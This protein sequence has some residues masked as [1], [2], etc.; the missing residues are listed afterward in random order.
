MFVEEGTKSWQYR[1]F[2]IVIEFD[3]R[4]KKSPP[5]TRPAFRFYE[6]REY[7]TSETCHSSIAQ[8]LSPIFN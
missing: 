4:Q 3:F 5:V 1:V 7:R 8:I 2:R 6:K